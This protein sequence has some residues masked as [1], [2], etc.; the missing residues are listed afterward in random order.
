M[1]VILHENVLTDDF[2]EGTTLH[3]FT[4]ANEWS[5]RE[6]IEE[7]KTVDDALEW[8]RNN[9]RD[10]VV[11]QGQYWYCEG[12]NADEELTPDDVCETDAIDA[13]DM[14]V[15]NVVAYWN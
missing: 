15:A 1:Q 4:F 14:L 5:D 7:F 9:F 6:H 2:L 13:W 12:L 11:H 10:R 8:Y 3:Y